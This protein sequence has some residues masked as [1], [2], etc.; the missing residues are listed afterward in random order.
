V[1]VNIVC[2]ILY[3]V[4]AKAII[5]ARVKM[6][7]K[8]ENNTLGERVAEVKAKA[9]L[10]DMLVAVEFDTAEDKLSVV[11]TKALV[12][13]LAY[14]VKEGDVQAL[15]YTLAKVDAE[16]LRYPLTDRLQVLQEE[17]VGNMPTKLECKAVLD[18]LASRETEVKVHTLCDTLSELKGME[19]LHTF[20]VT[21]A[22]NDVNAKA[23][24][25][26]MAARQTEVKIEKLGETS[27]RRK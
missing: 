2:E 12:D 8:V 3:E 6:Q 7:A 1:E 19:T 4:K 24:H 9:T 18:T 20:T 14:R 16:T 11:K 10:P 25:Y 27:Q 23:L 26:Q 21:V 17:K 15:C 5:E 13:T 22:K